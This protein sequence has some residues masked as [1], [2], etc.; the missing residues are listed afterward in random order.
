[1]TGIFLFLFFAILGAVAFTS[2]RLFR[3]DI[4]HQRKPATLEEQLR[5]ISQIR[6]SR[7]ELRRIKR[8]AAKNPTLK[9]YVKK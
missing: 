2:F 8:L 3:H 5:D 1:M 9:K 6:L 7:P 4:K